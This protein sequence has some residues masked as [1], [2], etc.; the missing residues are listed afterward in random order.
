MKF[1]TYTTSYNIF[2]KHIKHHHLYRS[3]IIIMS[4]QNVKSYSYF[5]RYMYEYGNL[6]IKD[7]AGFFQ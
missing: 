4:I 5:V 3:L 7:K 1:S 2:I 6:T